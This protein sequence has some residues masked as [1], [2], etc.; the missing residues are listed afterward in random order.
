MRRPFHRPAE[1]DRLDLGAGL[2]LGHRPFD[3]HLAGVHH[4]HDVGEAPDEVHVVLDDDDGALLADPLEQRARLLPL[5]G[6]HAGD[7]LVEEHHLGVLDEQHPD[8][9]PLLL[10]VGEHP[11]RTVPEV[12]QPDRLECFGDV[13]RDAAAGAEQCE[14]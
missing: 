1:V 6:T 4:R 8:L 11:C 14:R 5:L 9:E 2:D 7:G 12:G 3:Q 10:T 13:R